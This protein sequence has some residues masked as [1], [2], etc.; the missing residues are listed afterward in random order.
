[1]LWRWMHAARC[2]KPAN[3][4]RA[5]RRFSANSPLSWPTKFLLEPLRWG[6][7][8]SMHCLLSWIRPSSSTK[9]STVSR[10]H[11]TRDLHASRCKSME[12]TV[13]L[14]SIASLSFDAL[15]NSVLSLRRQDSTRLLFIRPVPLTTHAS[16]SVRC[17]CLQRL[18]FGPRPQLAQRIAG[19]LAVRPRRRLPV[20]HLP[21]PLP[22]GRLPRLRTVLEA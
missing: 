11:C 3:S 14:S 9:S 19:H 12:P 22:D 21:R 10:R 16:R 5:T 13:W 1:M 8:T 18:Q 4:G 2:C 7:R 15:R 6:F 20:T 17:V